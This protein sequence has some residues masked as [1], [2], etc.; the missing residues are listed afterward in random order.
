[1]TEIPFVGRKEELKDLSFLLKKNRQ[2]LWLLRG[3]VV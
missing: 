3:D 2:A 1:M